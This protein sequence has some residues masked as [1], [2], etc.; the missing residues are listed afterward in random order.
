ME[1]RPSTAI[2]M[3]FSKFRLRA[4][5]AAIGRSSVSPIWGGWPGS[6]LRK[7]REFLHVSNNFIADQHDLQLPER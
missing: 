5:E 7:S 1:V 3:P 6:I 2:T 4:V